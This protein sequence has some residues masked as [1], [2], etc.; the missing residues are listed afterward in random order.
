[1][2]IRREGPSRDVCAR[3][4][5]ARLRKEWRDRGRNCASHGSSTAIS[6][7]SV[8]PDGVDLGERNTPRMGPDYDSG[9]NSDR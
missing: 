1:M 9:G 2:T 3:A 4:H 5:A 6:D 7:A 8:A